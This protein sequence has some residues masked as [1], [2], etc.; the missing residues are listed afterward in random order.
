MPC[1]VFRLSDEC[2]VLRSVFKQDFELPLTDVFQAY[3]SSVPAASSA[4]E[5]GV[6]VLVYMCSGQCFGFLANMPRQEKVHLSEMVRQ[7]VVRP[8]FHLH[9]NAFTGMLDAAFASG[10]PAAVLGPFVQ[11][12]AAMQCPTLTSVASMPALA[13][14]L[15][16][17]NDIRNIE[18]VTRELV[19]MTTQFY[20]R[21]ADIYPPSPADIHQ[22]CMAWHRSSASFWTM[23]ALASVLGVT[24][25]VVARSGPKGAIQRVFY[26]YNK[27]EVSLK[28]YIYKKLS[29]LSEHIMSGEWNGECSATSLFVD[30]NLWPA[31][32]RG[33][34][35]E[36]FHA[37]KKYVSEQ[38][39][40]AQALRES[41]HP[42]L[43]EA[44]S[45]IAGRSICY[46]C[47]RLADHTF[48]C[49]HVAFCIEC[50]RKR[51]PQLT[52]MS[53][54]VCGV[55]TLTEQETPPFTYKDTFLRHETGQCQ[56]CKCEYPPDDFPPRDASS[57]KTHW[58]SCG[59]I[60]CT[61][62]AE[63]KIRTGRVECP[64]CGK[65][66]P[67]I[68]F[69]LAPVC[70]RCSECGE[71]KL[72][73]SDFTGIACSSH[74]SC[75]DC[76]VKW[77]SLAKCNKCQREVTRAELNVPRQSS[78]S[79]CNMLLKGE[80]VNFAA[81]QCSVCLNCFL[82]AGD[83][84]S[85][86]RCRKHFSDKGVVAA[87]NHL[88]TFF[89]SPEFAEYER[90]RQEVFSTL[91]HCSMCRE[92]TTD[93]IKTVKVGKCSHVMH[94]ACLA[95]HI[96]TSID[97]GALICPECPG[98]VSETWLTGIYSLISPEDYDKLQELSITTCVSCSFKQFL[99]PGEDLIVC[100]NCGHMLCRVCKQPCDKSHVCLQG[101][102]P[103]PLEVDSSDIHRAVTKEN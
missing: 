68:V 89:D 20:L 45:Y 1:F 91:A 65:E 77:P 81:C 7:L 58:M 67:D 3:G 23:H 62:C 50:H 25:I 94:A 64:V 96:R 85:C 71:M 63:M 48:S 16:Y 51:Y 21:H 56:Q 52:C 24:L 82:K 32:L 76:Q 40:I 72:W 92:P 12:C 47:F 6:P 35:I 74:R 79:V 4:L 22:R 29:V 80:V 103:L 66:T 9:V 31:L 19:H 100:E 59:D 83:V 38:P 36:D 90:A 33:L 28:V 34:A 60:L 39:H 15:T 41:H 73:L 11:M 44:L 18:P 70:C 102:K 97:K 98:E 86:C 37:M 53:C 78:C 75:E 27:A 46:L 61:F 57:R 88:S 93:L 17:L 26:P 43:K 69:Q 30:T 10:R 101:D 5:R 14:A 54:Q 84:T 8:A 42:I 95:D 55:L 99:L 2:V 87:Y 13:E 49:G